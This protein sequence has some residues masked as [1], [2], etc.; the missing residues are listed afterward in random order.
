MDAMFDY[1]RVCEK[2]VREA[3]ATIQQWIGRTTV[4]HKGPADLVTEADFAAQEVIRQ[5]VLGAFPDHALLGEEGEPS[6]SSSKPA[7]YRWIADP[8][9]GT[10]NYV[11]R[12]PH[13]C[14]SL[15]LEHDGQAVVGAVFDPTRDECFTAAAGQGAR[16]NG[17]PIHTS[18]VMRLSDGL[19]ATGFPAQLTPD[20]LDFLV[21]CAAAYRCQG[22]RRAGS[23]ALNLCYLAAGRYDALWAFSTKIW[24]VAAGA[25]IVGE[26][27]GV[28]TSPEGGPFVLE[29]PFYIAAAN[30][31]LHAELRE[32]VRPLLK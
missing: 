12:V 28:I 20:S 4:R 17:Q 13:Y 27:G 7:A 3:G 26:A 15:A 10:T 23:A 11:H 29:R 14:V 30:Q 21:F 31:T 19:G 1:L 18:G 24:D 8:L 22:V 5:A 9:D 32:L 6:G 2:A 16:L 25:L